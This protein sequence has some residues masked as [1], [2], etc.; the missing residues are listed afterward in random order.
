MIMKLFVVLPE[1]HCTFFISVIVKQRVQNKNNNNEQRIEFATLIYI[2][3]C[4]N[5][6]TKQTLIYALFLAFLQQ[7]VKLLGEIPKLLHFINT[8]KPDVAMAT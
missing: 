8:S 5:K 4:R 1:N 3:Q 2:Y 6:Q 7:T